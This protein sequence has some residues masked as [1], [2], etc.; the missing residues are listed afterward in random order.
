[1]RLRKTVFS[2]VCV[3]GISILVL[4]RRNING[5]TLVGQIRIV[6]PC[7]KLNVVVFSVAVDWHHALTVFVRVFGITWTSNG[8]RVIFFLIKVR[9]VHLGI[10]RLIDRPASIVSAFGS[11][12]WCGHSLILAYSVWIWNDLNRLL[13]SLIISSVQL[14]ILTLVRLRLLSR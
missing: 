7:S 12:C 10:F 11:G 2:S 1:M 8:H 13:G 5:K 14:T 9:N 6:R 3:F 4:S